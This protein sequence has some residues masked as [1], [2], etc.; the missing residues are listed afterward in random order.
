MLEHPVG[1][2]TEELEKF[3]VG[4]LLG[5]VGRLLVVDVRHLR[6]AVHALNGAIWDEEE[7]TDR[8]D[9]VDGIF[10]LHVVLAA[11]VVLLVDLLQWNLVSLEVLVDLVRV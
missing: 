9:E 8:L 7:A 2:S 5:L 3:D 11:I 6:V 10:E 4:E 1:N